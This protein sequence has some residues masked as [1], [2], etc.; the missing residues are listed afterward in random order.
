MLVYSYGGFMNKLMIL[1]SFL[2]LASCGGGFH[3]NQAG[4]YIKTQQN[5]TFIVQAESQLQITTGIQTVKNSHPLVNF[6]LP[7]AHAV[8][9]EQ[10]V[11]S[12]LVSTNVSSGVRFSATF[13]PENVTLDV[14]TGMVKLGTVVITELND[15]NVR[16]CGNQPGT[17]GNKRCN[18]AYINF[19]SDT[20]G[21]LGSGEFPDTVPLLIGVT[22]STLQNINSENMVQSD[23]ITSN[24]FKLN[25]LTNSSFEIWAD[26][27]G[28]GDG[29]YTTRLTVQYA[30]GLE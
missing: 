19:Y 24:R 15:N 6:L 13:V 1:S 11:T 7:K 4:L 8:N 10:A 21:L 5:R 28:V 9:N 29:T 23:N 16:K 17:L 27:S 2:L 26:F 14:S 30:I 3:A 20:S 18:K 22:E 25:Q 12:F